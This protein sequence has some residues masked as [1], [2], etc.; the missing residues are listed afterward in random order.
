MVTNLAS[1]V[2]TYYKGFVVIVEPY[3]VYQD[4]HLLYDPLLQFYCMDASLATSPIFTKFRNVI[5]TSGTIS[6]MEIY[7]KMLNF[8]PRISRAFDIRL[9]RNAIEPL[10]MTKGAD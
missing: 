4:D 3:P 1:L 10:I 6:P 8:E 9:P 7:P 5:L 2:A